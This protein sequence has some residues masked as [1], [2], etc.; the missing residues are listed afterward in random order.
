LEEVFPGCPQVR[1]G[2]LYPND[3]PGLGIDIDETAAARFPV[4][5]KVVEWTQARLP[6]GSMG[7]P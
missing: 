7:R 4:E 6:D 5:P 3:N 2:Y 1:D